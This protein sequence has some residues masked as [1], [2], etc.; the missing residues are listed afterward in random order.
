MGNAAAMGSFVQED[1]LPS[2]PLIKRE[3]SNL[4][5]GKWSRWNVR[6]NLYQSMLMNYDF[7]CRCW[8]DD[9]AANSKKY[10]A[11]TTKPQYR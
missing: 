4:D 6:Y 2:S 7:T 8:N 11:I 10:I 9:P 5:T 1:V 3:Q